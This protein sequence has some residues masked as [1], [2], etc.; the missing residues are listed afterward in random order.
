M[1]RP[2][3]RQ[4]EIAAGADVTTRAPLETEVVERPSLCAADH[5][6]SSLANPKLVYLVR[7]EGLG[8]VFTSQVVRPL[9]RIAAAGFDV[10]LVVLCPV[11]QLVRKRQREQ[12]AKIDAG[13]PEN[14]A[15]RVHRLLIPPSRF[16]WGWFE[17]RVVA[18]FLRRLGRGS[19]EFI[20]QC[21]NA[22]TTNLALDVKCQMPRMR[23]VYD[24]RGLEDEELLYQRQGQNAEPSASSRTEAERLAGLQ[25]RAA[26]Q[27][28][29]VFCVSNAMVDHLLAR[30][31]IE[32]GKCRVVPCSVDVERFAAASQERERVRSTLG[33]SDRFVTAYCGSLAAW[34]LPEQTLDLFVRI[35]GLRPEAHF[36]AVTTQPDKMRELIVRKR[37]P[38]GRSTVV[39][40]RPDEVPR[41]LA[42]ADCGFLLRE[43]SPVNQVASPVKFAEYL[44]SGTPVITNDGIGDYSELMQSERLGLVLPANAFD[45]TTDPLLEG[46]LESVQSDPKAWHLRCLQAARD[47]L[48]ADVYLPR[49]EQ[50]YSRLGAGLEANLSVAGERSN[51]RRV[52]PIRVLHVISGRFYGGGQRV[53]LDLLKVLPESANVDAR[54]CCLGESRDSPLE[55]RSDATVKYNGRYNSPRVLWGTARRLRNVIAAESVDI[56]HTH[57]VDADLIGGLALLGRREQQVCHLHVSPPARREKSWKAAVRRRLLRYLT[58]RNGSWFIAVSDS[59]RDAMACYYRLPPERM[60][61]VR[62]GIDPCEFDGPA[63]AAARGS[64]GDR[65]VFGTAARLERAKGL[66]FL[67]EAGGRL[68]RQQISFEI[69]IAGAGSQRE[70]LEQL[71]RSLNIADIVHFLG[72]VRPADMPGFYASLDVFVLPSL[73]EGLPLV[74]LEAMAMAKPVAA[75]RLAG[76]PEVIRDGVDGLLVPP[77]DAD[78]LGDALAKLA[79]DRAWRQQLGAAARERVHGS[80]RL[81]RVAREI[82][83]VYERVLETA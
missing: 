40:A 36:L 7:R 16:E 10:D 32:R 37:I 25:R 24:C 20:V 13:L 67:I 17:R 62:N 1:D 8:S 75:S 78:A 47:H 71:A 12:W 57:G 54:L 69:R 58:G 22:T 74:M 60:T 68:A 38:E 44:A 27:S 77:G 56:V 41:Y 6:A 66:E 15:G 65:V 63:N 23:V 28:D 11:G 29:A 76:I 3:S 53:V 64:Q 9:S 46:F 80:F 61:T 2:A 82:A 19:R 50:L 33:L 34:Q 39:S 26:R 45:R 81:E 73:S 4:I 31:G 35:S 14:L 48:D 59:V 49:I 18:K 21:R 72:P 30:Y 79:G 70:S 55:P 43:T 83:E 52:K 51:N 5:A 42:A